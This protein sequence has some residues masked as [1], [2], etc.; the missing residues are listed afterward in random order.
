M[1]NIIINNPKCTFSDIRKQLVYD[2][3]TEI[4]KGHTQVYLKFLVDEGYVQQEGNRYKITPIAAAK[5]K[6]E[7]LLTKEWTIRER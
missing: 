2:Q 6:K 1:I 4:L 5:I 7:N 3:Q